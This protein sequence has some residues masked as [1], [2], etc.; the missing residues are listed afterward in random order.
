AMVVF[1]SP[2]TGQLQ[3][4]A[5]EVMGTFR[6]HDM[7]GRSMLEQRANGL[8]AT[9]NLSLETGTYLLTVVTESGRLIR[10]KFIVQANSSFGR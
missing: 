2:C 5:N 4:R 8:T 3:V 10:R 6:V 9:L 1:P 7:M